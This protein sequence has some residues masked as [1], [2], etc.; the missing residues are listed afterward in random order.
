[1]VLIQGRVRLLLRQLTGVATL[2][3]LGSA[4]Q[5]YAR[6]CVFRVTD[7]NGGVVYI[8]GSWHALRSRDYPL[9]APYNRAFDAANRLS[10]EIAPKEES[11]MARA[12]PRAGQYSRGDSMKNHVD[13]R[14]YEYL[15]RF[16]A[17]NKV[18]EQKFSRYKPWFIA[19]SLGSGGS[20][21]SS[22]LGVE[23]FLEKRANANSKPVTGVETLR[24]HLEVFSG[25]SDR[26]SEAYLL[27]TLIPADKNSP[28]FDRMLN[29]WR[30]GD[31]DFLANSVYSDFK[32]F[33]AMATRLLAARNRNW[34]PKIEN[35]IRS[36][37]TYFVVVGA[38]HL[39]RSDGVI[40]LLKA[41]GY[42]VE[43]L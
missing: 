39:G 9:P 30:E 8:G 11:G 36:G 2:V 26:S 10:F 32:D 20:E 15:K 41:R 22:Q 7:P 13:P 14:T 33:P 40:A 12:M 5:V 31:I 3:L 28:N 19:M 6:S 29:A 18:P 27:F 24:E 17:A 34:I 25:L 1:V 16:F 42:K 21:F 37:Q 38:A 4:S 35:Y 23:S 43:Q